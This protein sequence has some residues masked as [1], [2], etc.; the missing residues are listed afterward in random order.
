[1][2]MIEIKSNFKQQIVRERRTLLFNL[3]R[4]MYLLYLSEFNVFYV[5]VYSHII[6]HELE[7]TMPVIGIF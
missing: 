2:I 5:F 3:V 7:V 6:P 4:H 1:M